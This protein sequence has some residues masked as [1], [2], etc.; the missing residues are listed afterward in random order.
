MATVGL[1]DVTLRRWPSAA[2]L[3]RLHA[4]DFLN[5]HYA[6]SPPIAIGGSVE[7]TGT[8]GRRSCRTRSLRR[9]PSAA[10]LKRYGE[11]ACLHMADG[12]SA[13]LDRR[14]R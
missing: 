7:A 8:R 11:L 3:K 14:L 1:Y 13:D 9:S 2:P 12:L 6:L 5:G 4:S 10:P